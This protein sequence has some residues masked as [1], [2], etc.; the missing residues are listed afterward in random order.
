MQSALDASCAAAAVLDA[1]AKGELTST[2]AARIKALVDGY[3]RK[4]EIAELE[5]RILALE[6]GPGEKR[7]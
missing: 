7:P 5:A 1:V 6:A 3:W 4:L 2:E